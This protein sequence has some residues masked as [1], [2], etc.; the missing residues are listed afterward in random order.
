MS[1]VLQIIDYNE[2]S[3]ALI[4]NTVDFRTSII[5][6]GGIYNPMITFKNEMIFGWIFPKNKKNAVQT[7]VDII[8]GIDSLPTI[9]DNDNN[10]E[11]SGDKVVPISVSQYEEL[12]EKFEKLQQLVMELKGMVRA[13]RNLLI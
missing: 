3:I 9:N 12:L 1:S 2:S 5:R 6:L 8:N 4:G 11:S 13:S 7:F 10:V